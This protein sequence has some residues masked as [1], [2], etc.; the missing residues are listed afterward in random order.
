MAEPRASRS[1]FGATRTAVAFGL[2]AVGSLALY[3][4]QSQAVVQWRSGVDYLAFVL[5]SFAQTPVLH[6]IPLDGPALP[7][8]FGTMAVGLAACVAV[9]WFV[10]RGMRASRGAAPM[11]WVAGL[12]A[13]VVPPMLIASARWPDGQ[14][15][16]TNGVLAIGHALLVPLAWWWA[17]SQPFNRVVRTAPL[18]P[19]SSAPPPLADLP[20]GWATIL[21]VVA[22]PLAVLV[23]V[24]GLSSIKGYDSFSDHIARPA[25]WLATGRLV[26]G[27]AEEVV[28]HYPGNFELLVRWTLSLGTDRFAFLVAY[29]SSAASTWVVYRLAREVDQGRVAALVSALA[30]ASL[31]VLAYQSVVVYSDSFTA[32]CLLLATWLLLVWIREGAADRRLVFGFGLALGLAMGAKYSAGPPA[33]VLGL[34]WTW[35]ACRDVTREGFEQP[36]VDVRWLAPQLAWL[37]AGVLPGMAFWYARNLVL[38]GNPFYPLSVAGLPGIPL[39]SL[40]AGAPGPKTLGEIVSYPWLE[41]GH[42]PGFETGLGATVA[43]IVVLAL[44][45]GPLVANRRPRL[46]LLWLVWGLTFLA[47]VQSGVMVPRYGLYP[48]LLAFVFVGALLSAYPSGLLRSVATIAIT[49]TMLAVGFEMAG[50]TAYSALLYDPRP[51]VPAAIDS[52]PA[53]QILNLAGEP[54]GYYAMGHDYRH[55]VLSPFRQFSPDDARA[56][57]LPYLLLPPAREAEFRRA[58]PLQFMGRYGSDNGPGSSLWHLP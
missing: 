56:A 52:L 5:R 45:A 10:S 43:T 31:Q 27:V 44:L 11:G 24:N 23:L 3:L 6:P 9:G 7:W 16:V 1:F 58:L 49:G 40:L 53:T 57:K 34:L 28:T 21:L 14:G 50:G 38:Q 13:A 35:H 20:R 46:R 32:L 2:A 36:L 30:A 54:A 47:W 39:G 42:G 18:P 22:V 25:R 12:A 41:T 19:R 29:G 4:A 37:V 17:R 8:A 55:R 48:I 15:S 51:P 33:V 26:P